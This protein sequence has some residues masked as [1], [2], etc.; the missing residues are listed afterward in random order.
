MSVFDKAMAG[1]AADKKAAEQLNAQ[2]L[3]QQQQ[4]L[5]EFKLRAEAGVKRLRDMLSADANSI[6]G[7]GG[8]ADLHDQIFDSH[9]V[10][11]LYFCF[12]QKAYE[13]EDLP[14]FSV[15]LRVDG[16][17]SVSVGASAKMSESPYGANDLGRFRNFDF[18]APS[19]DEEIASV[20]TTV[21]KDAHQFAE[22]NRK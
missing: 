5:A 13:K 4:K 14:V 15:T 10:V 16:E 21:Y 6:I 12:S 19:F 18:A 9:Y 3:A 7:S 17:T 2:A 1:I 11:T 8:T 22:K 20:L